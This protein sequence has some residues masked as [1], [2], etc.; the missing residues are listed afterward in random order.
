VDAIKLDT[1]TAEMIETWRADFIKRGSTNPLK[2]K[3]ARI[4]A[5]SFIGRARSLFGADVIARVRDTVELPAPAPFHGV[6]VEKIRVPRYRST[7]DMAALLEAARAELPTEQ[8]KIFFLAAM[9]G[10]RRREIDLLPWTA[11]RWNEGVIR[12]ETTQ[13]FRP[14]SRE[15]EGSVQVDAELLE[16]FR[17]YHARAKSEFVIESDCAPD[18][19]APFESY[20]CER[21]IDGL[22][23]WLRGHGVT[24]RTPLHTLRKQYG[25]EINARYGL[26]AASDALRHAN[27]STTVD[28]YIENHKRSVLGFGH[29][30]NSKEKTIIPMEQSA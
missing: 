22:I 15:S 21:E 14:K 19:A 6:K 20:R 13:Y 12:I 25:S 10:L 7:F 27:I 17:G 8:L 3:S 5:N 18:P 16:L 30:L 1:L 28:H 11:F 26:T 4:S 9:A 29:L 24:S 2:E 23:A